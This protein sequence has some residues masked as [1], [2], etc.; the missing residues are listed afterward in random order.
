[1]LP[2]TFFNPF[3]LEKVYDLEDLVLLKEE[4][5][6]QIENNYISLQVCMYALIS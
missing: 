1:M 5:V 4:S 6:N 3:N 2:K